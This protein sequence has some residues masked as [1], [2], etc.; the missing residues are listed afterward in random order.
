MIITNLQ[1]SMKLSNVC[2]HVGVQFTETFNKRLLIIKTGEVVN[3]IS[4]A[5]IINVMDV[6]R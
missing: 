5:L 2:E 4:I 6:A 3:I 1:F